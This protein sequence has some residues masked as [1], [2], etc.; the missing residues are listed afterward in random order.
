MEKTKINYEAT[1]QLGDSI[2]KEASVYQDIYAQQ[3][4]STFKN[5]IQNCYQGD[6]ATTAIGQL[7]GL[8]NDFDAMRDVITEYGKQLVKAAQDYEEDMRASK[9]AA[10]DLA[11]NRK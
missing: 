11:A 9:V 6:D 2:Q 10:S 4:Y 7:D 5:S 1:R 3:I 8:R